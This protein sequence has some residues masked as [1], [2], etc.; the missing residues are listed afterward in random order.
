VPDI[1]LSHNGNGRSP[2]RNGSVAREREA[3]AGTQAWR[4]EDVVIVGAA[5]TP[6]GSF[7]GNLANVPATTLGSIAIKG[8]TNDCTFQTARESGI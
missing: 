2:K 3:M 7:G 5:R 8:K 6:I 4:R 1:G